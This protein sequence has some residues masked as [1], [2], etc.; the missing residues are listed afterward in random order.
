LAQACEE[1][2]DVMAVTVMNKSDFRTIAALWRR[3]LTALELGR[4][5]DIREC[6]CC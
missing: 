3:H 5:S 4:V 1:R 2:V 6:C